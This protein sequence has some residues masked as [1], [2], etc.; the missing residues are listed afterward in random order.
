MLPRSVSERYRR[1]GRTSATAERQCRSRNGASCR[2]RRGGALLRSDR[3]ARRLCASGPRRAYPQVCIVETYL[4]SYYSTALLGLQA[5]TRIQCERSAVAAP[6][7]AAFAG[8]AHGSESPQC[9]ARRAHACRWSLR[10]VLRLTAEPPSGDA[11]AKQRHNATERQ[12]VLT[13]NE[14]G[15]SRRRVAEWQGCRS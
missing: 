14:A 6:R 2:Q 12:R 11:V 7:T 8:R 1:A 4:P 3:P 15:V 10:W 9:T 13:E 5:R